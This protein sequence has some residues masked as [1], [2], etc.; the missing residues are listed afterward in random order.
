M[1]EDGYKCITNIDIS[2]TVIQAMGEKYKNFGPD[3]KYVQM[4]AR[5]MDFPADSFE[6]VLDK[7]TLDSMLV[8]YFI[9]NS[10]WRSFIWKCNFNDIRSVSSAKDRRSLHNN[11]LR[12]T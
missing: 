12:S 9:L 7:A 6:C 8:Y 3:F 10:V 11:L 5:K 4:D 2:P 1:F